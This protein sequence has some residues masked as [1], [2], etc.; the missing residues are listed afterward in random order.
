MP[1]HTQLVCTFPFSSSPEHNSLASW[2]QPKALMTA[3]GVPAGA[4]S[5]Q[6]PVGRN[7]Q[8]KPLPKHAETKEQPVVLPQAGTFTP[9]CLFP[10][11]EC[12]PIWVWDWVWVSPWLQGCRDTP[13]HM[14][15][16]PPHPEAT[17]R[18]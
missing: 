13:S 6:L 15:L 12:C 2:Q 7:C 16:A 8:Q 18:R 3:R 5:F 4:K 1:V 17:Y 10:D 14:V 11:T 9:Q